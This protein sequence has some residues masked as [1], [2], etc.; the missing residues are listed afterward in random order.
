MKKMNE[1][2]ELIN[3][4]LLVTLTSYSRPV[5]LYEP[6]RYTLESGGKRIRACLLLMSANLFTDDLSKAIHAALG[7]EIFHNF[8]LLHDDIMDKA[9]VRRGKPSVHKMWDSNTAILSGDAM[10]IIAYKLLAESGTENLSDV[11]NT[12]SKTALQVCVG[13]QLD[14][15]LEKTDLEQDPPSLTDYMHMIELKT[16]V[17]I[18]AA[19]K[20]GAQVTG[21]R[22]KLAN[23][24]YE[25]GKNI[26]I[27]FQLQ[28]DYL[29]T[30]GNFKQFG[31]R[32]G[33]DIAENKKTYLLLTALQKASKEDKA[34]LL[35][36]YQTPQD[37]EHA[38]IKA[39]TRIF[40][41]YNLRDDIQTEIEAYFSVADNILN[42]ID[43]DQEKLTNI[44]EL[45][46]KL[47][48]RNY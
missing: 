39:V 12:F 14:M 25:Y 46:Q 31:K 5:N 38:K 35:N 2:V 37:D 42:E 16:S 23:M 24:L 7:I 22:P 32:I 26:G 21:A 48:H 27:A 41:K 9:E 33:G 13:Q 28:D 34:T 6:I 47:R 4:E 36:L 20:I 8:T 3:K 45:I 30:F 29:D 17:L 1:L 19:F 15:D 44:K 18:G 11:L 43:I 40:E 10:Q